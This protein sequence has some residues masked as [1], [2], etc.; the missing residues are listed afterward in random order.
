[1][2]RGVACFLEDGPRKVIPRRLPC[3]AHMVGSANLGKA[4]PI[5]LSFKHFGEN[6]TRRGGHDRSAR[7][8]SDLITYNS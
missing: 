2:L 8:R 3:R 6:F 5:G 1:M 4:K 7:G